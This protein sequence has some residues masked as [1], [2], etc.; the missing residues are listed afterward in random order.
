LY[1]G[2]LTRFH[3]H[4]DPAQQ[5]RRQLDHVRSQLRATLTNLKKSLQSHLEL[6]FPALLAANIGPDSVRAAKILALAATAGTWLALPVA[7]RQK[8]AGPKQADLDQA[9]TQSLADEAIAQACVPAVRTL[10][11]AQQAIADQLHACEQDIVARRPAQRV[12]L[13]MSIPGF[14]ERTAAVWSTYLPASF[15]GWGRK[16]KIVARLQALSGTDR[17]L[18]SSGQWVGHTKMS[19]RGITSARTALFQSA[20]CSLRSDPQNADYYAKLRAPGV[21]LGRGGFEADIAQAIPG[22]NLAGGGYRTLVGIETDKLRIR[23][24]LGHDRG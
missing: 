12:A 11:A 14:G 13:I 18:R 15:E 6:V 4:S 21:I 7:Q 19:K 1:A 2:D 23:K 3:Y 24:R 17:R 5:A 8:L 9:A 22:R 16:K 20:F 10:L